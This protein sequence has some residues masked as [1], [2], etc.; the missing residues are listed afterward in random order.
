MHRRELL[1]FGAAVLGVS[2]SPSCSRAVLSEDDLHA[3]TG[4]LGDASATVEILCELILPAGDTPGAIDA[5]VPDFVGNIVTS[6]YKDFERDHF[7]D[8]IDALR[9]ASRTRFSADFVDLTREQQNQLVE[10][11]AR[12]AGADTAENLRARVPGGEKPFFLMLRELV[13]LG[14]FTSEV[15]ATE[16]LRYNPVPGSYDGA[17]PVEQVRTHW[18]Y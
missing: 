5:G 3:A 16:V 14:F 18:S 2:V 12:E 10:E 13:V 6:W 7:M 17:Y 11:A 4:A 1:K 15:G 8:G 9:G